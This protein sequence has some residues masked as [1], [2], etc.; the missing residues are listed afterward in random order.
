MTFTNKLF[1]YRV[2][3]LC[4]RN[5]FA[6]TSSFNDDTAGYLL[7]FFYTTLSLKKKKTSLCHGSLKCEKDGRTCKTQHCGKEMKKFCKENYPHLIGQF[8]R[9]QN[10]LPTVTV[11][12]LCLGNISRCLGKHKFEKSMNFNG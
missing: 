11:L 4:G 3:L 9:I 2:I 10:G 5:V 7:L 1:S 6:S 8:T 12:D